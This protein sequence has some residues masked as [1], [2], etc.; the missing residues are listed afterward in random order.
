MGRE[1]GEREAE[2]YSRSRLESVLDET[3]LTNQR[4]GI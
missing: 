4:T 2:V 3:S 1:E